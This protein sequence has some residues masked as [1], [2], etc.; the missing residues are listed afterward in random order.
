MVCI[1][2]TTE[3]A[4]THVCCIGAGYVGGP[5]SA[6]MAL[7]CSDIEFTV[8]DT[9]AK[10]IAA[11]NSSSLP[12]YEP[13]LDEIVRSVR[14]AN[15]RFTT[16]IDAAI[17]AADIV[18]IAVNTPLAPSGAAADAGDGGGCAPCGRP[19]DLS[20]VEQCVMRIAHAA[21]GP[22]VVVEKSTVPCKTGDVVASILQR[23]GHAGAEFAVL[24]NPEFLSEG[25]AVRDLLDPDRV[26][27]GGQRGT[28]RAQAALAAVY[29]HWVAPDRI[30]TMGLWS[31][32][33]A[34]LA[35]NAMLAQRIS[36]I[37]AISAV[38][39]ATGADV[40]DVA[41]GCAADSR[42]GDKYLRAS[43]GFGGSC[44]QKDIASLV[45]LCHS[46]G[47]PEV[48]EY[49]HQVLRVNEYQKSRFAQRIVHVA[50]GSLAG[51]RVACLGFA[52]KAETGDARNTPAAA[53][54]RTLLAHGAQLAIYDP[55]VPAQSIIEHLGDPC[56]AT[57]QHA[58]GNISSSSSSSSRVRVCKS[59][60][61]A[62]DGACVVAILAPWDEFR[63][64]DWRRAAS[65]LL[66]APQPFVFDGQLVV[67]DV[68]EL[69][70]LGLQVHAVGRRHVTSE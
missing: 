48:A 41:R 60:Y 16:D 59:A 43:V 22:T 54:C 45:W 23:H 21:R 11:W 61:Q 25:T 56:L 47:L 40:A 39:E 1:A 6:V 8:V 28:E 12:V 15:L 66:D 68:G 29:A 37:N 57:E 55:K 51:R 17:R 7:K 67:D 10:R 49:W 9:D 4:A 18:M 52:Y 27:I 58:K 69:E 13:G 65:L 19:T 38:C 42:I 64:I 62:M 50:G 2:Q 14:G 44:F 53:V 34:K 46:L 35:S 3:K 31:A 36:S 20:A 26:I 63:H 32:E 70:G 5:T 24:A 33:L 30:V